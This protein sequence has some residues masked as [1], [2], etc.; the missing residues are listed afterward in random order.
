MLNR[1]YGILQFALVIPS[2]S[3]A[4]SDSVCID[5]K[6]YL[7]QTAGTLISTMII[8]LILFLRVASLYQNHIALWIAVGLYYA[9]EFGIMVYQQVAASVYV[10]VPEGAWPCL[11]IE[12]HEW[13]LVVYVCFLPSQFSLSN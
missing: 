2:L 3:G 6:F 4:F 1:Y 10:P 12:W 8:Q 9:A 11:A 5:H 13:N 7:W